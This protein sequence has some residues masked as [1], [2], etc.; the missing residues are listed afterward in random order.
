MDMDIS[1]HERWFRAYAVRERSKERE[2]PEPLVLK[3]CHTMAVLANARRV[4]ESEALASVPGRAC[5][6]AALYHDVA[7]F[8]QYLRYRTFRDRDSVNHGQYGVRI[9]RRE[10]CLDDEPRRVRHLA[11]AGVALHNR[12]ALPRRLPQDVALVAHVVRDADKLDILRVMDGHLR[13]R[14][15]NPTV[16]LQLPDDSEAASP[17]IRKAALAGR[18]A[19]YA[20]LRSV[21]DF[22]L[23]LGTWFFDMH[24]TASRRQ[25]VEDG[26]AVNILKGLPDDQ[27]YGEARAFLLERLIA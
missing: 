3:E 22:R 26:H 14:P 2:D 24:F 4:V 1:R 7:R 25:F 13:L 18:V 17:E 10:G 6:L 20:D 19:A 11:M 12:F 15:Y 21:N 5:L 16:V 23:L 9:L 8:E 27:V